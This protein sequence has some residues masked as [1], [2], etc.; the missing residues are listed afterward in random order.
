[1]LNTAAEL[2]AVSLFLAT[3]LLWAAILGVTP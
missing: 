3:L 1:L 2:V